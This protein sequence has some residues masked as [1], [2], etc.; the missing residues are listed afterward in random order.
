MTSVKQ[1]VGLDVHEDT[2]AI[3][4]APGGPGRDVQD[5]GTIPTIGTA[6]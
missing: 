3:A 1:Y 4:V 2:I 5:R 6:W